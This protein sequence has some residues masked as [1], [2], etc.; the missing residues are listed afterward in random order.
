M[1]HASWKISRRLRFLGRVKLLLSLLFA[2]TIVTGVLA[3][4]LSGLFHGGRTTYIRDF[5]SLVATHTADNVNAIMRDYHQRLLTFAR[6]LQDQGLPEREKKN[7]LEALFDNAPDFF[8]VGIYRNN[9]I[10]QE[11][12]YSTRALQRSRLTPDELARSSAEYSL[13]IKRIDNG[14]PF[15]LN[16]TFQPSMPIFILAIP[17]TLNRERIII[18][19]DI[20]M[21][22]LLRIPQK[23]SI[24]DVYI[25]DNDGN[26]LASKDAWRIAARAPPDWL[27]L[28]TLRLIAPLAQGRAAAISVEYIGRN[29]A[30]IGGFANVELTNM[31]VGV[32]IPTSAANLTVRGF[33]DRL[34]RA[35]VTLSM[36]LVL[37]SL[38]WSRRIAR[39]VKK[40]SYA[41]LK[42]G[43]GDFDVQVDVRGND[44]MSEL[45]RSFNRM[46]SEL[47]RREEA[48]RQAQ[49]ALIQSEKMAAFGQ[50]S[51][52][53]AHEVKNP[54]AGILGYVQLAIRKV[55][56]E[57][58]VYRHL[59]LIEKET[60]RCKNIIDNLMKFAR[61][62]AV[63]MRST[64][65]NQT[66]EEACVIVD[67]QLGLHRV[68]LQK[69][70]G[71]DLPP[72]MGN[73]NQIEQVLVNL[74]IN[75]D[76]AME[77]QGGTVTIT[78]RLADEN[79]LEIR[80]RDTGPGIPDE[81]K[82]NLFEPFFTTK[83][84][85]KGTGLGLA[86]SYGIVRDHHGEIRVEGTEGKGACF[87]ITLP[88]APRGSTVSVS[89]H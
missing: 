51:A 46:A 17:L 3:Y 37:L 5:T 80:V 47:H 85:G 7:R 87:I 54:L 82:A 32:E 33:L 35:S 81:F 58:P 30:I 25:M 6:V 70:L 41:A 44:E 68:H 53:I 75:A 23:E 34:T 8:S 88:A 22:S 61:Q 18:T 89:E 12:V 31:V 13:P 28:D 72:F 16:A 20:D 78:T 66:V 83:P 76:Q 60:K 74:M 69:E 1:K 29:V 86:V 62:E 77:E 45:A 52:G 15:V 55:D 65:L 24:F 4:T 27:P 19:A 42:I 63:E 21:R 2:I 10:E 9:S 71:A 14:R 67:H 38:I 11:R 56:K 49:A 43:Q 36:I 57:S 40:L 26:L 64:D 84:A 39:P 59:S 50:L 73:A 79:T 48:L